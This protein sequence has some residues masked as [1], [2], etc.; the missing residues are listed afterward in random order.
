MS[1]SDHQRLAQALATNLQHGRPSPK[2]A[3]EM[4]KDGTV[5]GRPLTKKQRGLFGAIVGRGR[6]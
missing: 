6:R 1:S 4:L 5:H 2:K 3:R